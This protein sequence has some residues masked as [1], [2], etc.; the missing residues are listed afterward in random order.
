MR[1]T[2]AASTSGVKLAANAAAWDDANNAFW[3][4]DDGTNQAIISGSSYLTTAD[5]DMNAM[6][7]IDAFEWAEG[8]ASAANEVGVDYS[9]NGNKSV[10]G[11]DGST[12][13][14]RASAFGTW[15]GGIVEYVFE[16]E[17]TDG[18]SADDVVQALMIGDGDSNQVALN[19]IT[20]S[21]YTK[22]GVSATDND[23]YMFVSVVF[24]K[25]YTNAATV[26]DCQVYRDFG[27]DIC[28]PSEYERDLFIY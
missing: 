22:M 11:T 4:M 20:D 23:P 18:V 25:G 2:N 24:A 12:T 5:T 3:T 16:I 26:A 7:A 15:T 21:T 14:T 28:D 9:T 6:S 17:Y 27:G 1:A 8:L 19:A 13:N 10:T